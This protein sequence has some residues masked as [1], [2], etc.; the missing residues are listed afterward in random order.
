[1]LI[2]FALLTFVSILSRVDGHG[3]LVLPVMWTDFEANGDTNDANGFSTSWVNGC[4]NKE[5]PL[6]A[7]KESDECPADMGSCGRCPLGEK[8]PTLKKWLKNPNC[9][10]LVIC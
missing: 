3:M 4:R 10:Y 5:F 2:I 6:K 9:N 8:C 1:M 7:F